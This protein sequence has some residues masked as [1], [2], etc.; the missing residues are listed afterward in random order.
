MRSASAMSPGATSRR[1]GIDGRCR[2][3]GGRMQ[4]RLRVFVARHNGVMTRHRGVVLNFATFLTLKSVMVSFDANTRLHQIQRVLTANSIAGRDKFLLL[5]SA[6]RTAWRPPLRVKS[7]L[8]P[9]FGDFM[10][11]SICFDE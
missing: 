3:N 8:V 9:F 2:V 6:P 1:R 4:S 11:A 7:N 5:V 10:V